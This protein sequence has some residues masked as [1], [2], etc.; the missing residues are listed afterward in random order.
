MPEYQ[1]AEAVSIFLSMPGK[2]VS[3]RGIVLDAFKQGKAVYIPYIHAQ[4]QTQSK[5]K[6]MDMLRLRDES[7]FD[8]LKPDS[9]G[10]PSLD[11][12]SIA[13]RENAVGGTGIQQMSEILS[14]AS[15]QLDLV[16][17]PAVAFDQFHRRLGHGKGF[18]DR[19]LQIYHSL[20][21]QA[22][23]SMP[24]LGKPDLSRSY[25]L[26]ALIRAH[27]LDLRFN[28]RCCRLHKMCR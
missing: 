28:N 15:P 5:V 11:T 6:V 9:W 4:S 10:I 7:D 23:K 12:E 21:T 24:Q 3:T 1:R 17:M 27:K 20:A 22:G 19:Y 26:C 8:S 16:F 25:L 14:N 2:E 13:Q 18:Y